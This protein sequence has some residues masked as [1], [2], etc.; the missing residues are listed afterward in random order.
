MSESACLRHRHRMEA[1]GLL[2]G[3]VAVLDQTLA[4]FPETV[5]VEV[6]LRSQQAMHLGAFEKALREIP[7]VMAC[8]SVSGGFDYLLRV[9]SVDA[10]HFENI[11][12]QLADLPGVDQIHSNF[13]LREVIKKTELPLAAET[14]APASSG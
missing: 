10:H 5:F 12:A 8:Y 9:I 2:A 4:G 6:S 1:T 13:A 11:R 3:Y 14:S 7:E